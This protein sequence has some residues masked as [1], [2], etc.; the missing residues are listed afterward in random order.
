MAMSPA[1]VL[2]VFDSPDEA[3]ARIFTQFEERLSNWTSI[4]VAIGDRRVHA[5]ELGFEYS[6]NII[7]RPKGLPLA[8]LWLFVHYDD[9]SNENSC[10]Q[11]HR[12]FLIDLVRSGVFDVVDLCTGVPRENRRWFSSKFE[13]RSCFGKEAYV[14]LYLVYR[15]LYGRASELSGGF[16]KFLVEKYDRFSADTEFVEVL[17]K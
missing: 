10:T 7:D 15:A 5:R 16:Q 8:Q 13:P 9:G 1:A 11:R 4:T 3:V 14:L 17:N 6:W 12:E 2:T